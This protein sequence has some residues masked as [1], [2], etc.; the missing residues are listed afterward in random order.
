MR[1]L[2]QPATSSVVRPPSIDHEPA[3]A[4]GGEARGTTSP[5]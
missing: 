5:S 3:D 1:I 4:G 2:V